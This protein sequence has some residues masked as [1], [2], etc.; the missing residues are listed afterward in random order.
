MRGASIL[1]LTA[2][3]AASAAFAQTAP[4]SNPDTAAKSSASDPATPPPTRHQPQGPTGP[5]ATTSG[6]AS[7]ASPQGDTPPGM[8][9]DPGNPK[10]SGA[11]KK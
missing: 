5:M 3:L 2:M 11:P 1:A 4:A 6:G 9:P 7:A 10:Q 8:Q